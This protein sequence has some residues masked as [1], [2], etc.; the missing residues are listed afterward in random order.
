MHAP[1][2]AP[3]RLSDLTAGAT[4]RFHDAQLDGELTRY[5]RAIGLTRTSEFRVCKNGEPC[6][7]QVRSTRIG[8]SRALA[9]RIRVV[10]VARKGV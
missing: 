6:I 8:L 7:L 9:G 10:P 4:A 2:T 3:V 1:L 5:L